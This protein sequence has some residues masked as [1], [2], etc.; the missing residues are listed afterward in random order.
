[1]SCS[2]VKPRRCDTWNN[3]GDICII[4]N[5][6]LINRIKQIAQRKLNFAYSYNSYLHNNR[7]EGIVGFVKTVSTDILI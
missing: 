3:L 1:M 2:E 5:K 4:L 7:T 6:V